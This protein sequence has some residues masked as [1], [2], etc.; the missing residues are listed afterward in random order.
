[1]SLPEAQREGDVVEAYARLL[2]D[3]DPEVR[4]AAA[5][6]WC[7]WESA[8]PAWPPTDGLDDRFRDSAFAL[9]F[10]RIVTHYVRHDAWLEDGE[11]LS[12]ASA[13]AGV[14]GVLV[15]GR[16]DMQSPIGSTWT[17]HRAWP[18]SELVVVDDAG[19]DAS[20]DRI[21]EAIVE[22]TDRFRDA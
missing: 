20:Q 1:M 18:G 6:A 7:R 16:W 15:K 4:R 12:G 11:L 19:H 14:P 10:A 8:T 9:A 13:L 3:P 21:V 2:F 17:L 22:A 5:E